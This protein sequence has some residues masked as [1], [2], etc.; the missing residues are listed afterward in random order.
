MLVI[1]NIA[2]TSCAE[3]AI[4][5]RILLRDLNMCTRDRSGIHIVSFKPGKRGTKF[6]F[7]IDD[8]INANYLWKR[9][10]FIYKLQKHG[11]THHTFMW[12]PKKT[13]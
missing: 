6:F 9:A 8:D 12:T 13:L 4:L 3:L 11:G 1:K 5:R 7:E 10:Q 2:I